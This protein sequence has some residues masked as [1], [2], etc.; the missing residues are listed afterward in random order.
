MT[1]GE[2][3]RWLE[4]HTKAYPGL[5]AW[6]TKNSGQLPFWE[7]VLKR[8]GY[9]HCTEATD[10]LIVSDDQP[11][12]YTD[13]AR[14]IARIARDVQ[15]S[16]TG[17]LR[18]KDRSV[19]DGHDVF[20][21]PLCQDTGFVYVVSPSTIREYRCGN[22]GAPRFCDVSCSCERGASIDGNEKFGRAGLV[23]YDPRKMIN[24]G[25]IMYTDDVPDKTIGEFLDPKYVLAKKLGV[26]EVCN[27]GQSGESAEAF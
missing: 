9:S 13:H 10:R 22:L 5:Q 12:G 27:V 14:A 3:D 26:M 17:S 24:W 23:R 4:Y 7:K 16:S 8:F 11:R 1:A 2:F 25:D 15:L 18:R 21:C 20:K 19:I 6:L